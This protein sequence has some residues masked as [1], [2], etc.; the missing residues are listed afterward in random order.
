MAGAAIWLFASRRRLLAGDSQAVC[1][2]GQECRTIC[3]VSGKGTKKHMELK[4]SQGFSASPQAVWD[5]L[6]NADVL[7]QAIAG[8]EEIRW[9]ANTLFARV[10]I[11]LGPVKGSYSAEAQETESNPPNHMKLSFNRQG[12]TNGIAGDATVDLAPNGSGT[13][14]TYVVNATLSGMIAAL[15][16][17]LTRPMVDKGASQFFASLAQKVS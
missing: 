7:K 15:D 11:G 4:G 14:L 3:S 16:N 8:A 10:N 13:T 2:E 12:S 6:H 17:P 1:G 5:A 9:D